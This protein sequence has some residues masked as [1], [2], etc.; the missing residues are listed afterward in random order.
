MSQLQKITP[1]LWFDYQ[2]KEAANFYCSLFNNSKI[3]SASDL[4]VEFQLDG[5]AF[6]ALNGGPKYK[7][8]E[9]ISFQV[10]CE[11]QEEVDH[12]WNNITSDGGEESQCSW[13]K[14][15]YGLSWQIVPKQF[16]E[17]MKSGNPEKSQKVM[18]AM[19]SMKK[20]IISELENA[21]N[22]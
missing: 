8:T 1:F 12:F 18:A 22:S 2:A 19:L 4:I 10:I 9:A 6:T 21:Y 7:F 3:I 17:M 5:L 14:D 15:K 13:C 16:I 11:D 20:L